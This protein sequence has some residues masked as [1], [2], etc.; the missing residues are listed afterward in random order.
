M[1]KKKIIFDFSDPPVHAL[2]KWG[3]P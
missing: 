1:K 2:W 3:P